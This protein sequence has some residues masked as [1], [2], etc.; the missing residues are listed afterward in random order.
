MKK[1]ASLH[2]TIIRDPES[3]N[4]IEYQAWLGEVKSRILDVHR[5]TLQHVNQELILLYWDIG[6]SVLS[7]Q[8]QHAWGAK[9]IDHLA[10]DL[11]VLFPDIKGFSI[12][13]LK[14]MRAFAEAWADKQ[15]VQQV[16]AQI[17]WSHNLI[18]LDKVKHSDIRVWYCQQALENGWS[19][20]AMVHQIENGLYER[21][22]NAKK[23]SNFHNKL[24]APTSDL[25]QAIIK[26]PYVF[27]F[28]RLDAGINELKLKSKLL[29]NLTNFLLE[30]G[31]GFAYI[32]S[33][34]RFEVNNDEFYVDLLFYHTRLHC[35]IVI[36]LKTGKFKP[37]YAG[38]LNFYITLVDNKLKKSD[39]NPTIGLLLCKEKNHLVAEYALK[40]I[41]QPMG[42]A[43][44]ALTKWVPKDIESELPSLQDFES[45]IDKR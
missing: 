9:I 3:N 20:N 26:D 44:Y 33:E 30:L 31:K 14:Y 11:K 17:S 22:V 1:P 37:E 45:I 32:G 28:L 19:R 41:N 21:Q 23:N 34:V 10:T 38:Q 2:S 29:S 36:E 42:I 16:L 6:K 12:R 8:N 35:Y 27:D 24:P 25:A 7:L 4:G 5:R 39:D 13:N 40:G 15:F 18:L 43:E